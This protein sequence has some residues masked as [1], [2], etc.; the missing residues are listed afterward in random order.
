M[1]NLI[2][3]IGKGSPNHWWRRQEGKL[4][5]QTEYRLHVLGVFNGSRESEE[6]PV[7]ITGLLDSGFSFL[8]TNCASERK[9]LR[10]RR[11]KDG[12]DTEHSVGFPQKKICTAEIHLLQISRLPDQ[13]LHEAYRG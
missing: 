1:V 13:L 12:V 7:A 2:N 9:S 6:L 10:E 8:T 11:Y 3:C 5:A 4:H